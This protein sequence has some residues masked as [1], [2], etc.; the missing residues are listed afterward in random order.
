MPHQKQKNPLTPRIEN[1]T[2][3]YRMEASTESDAAEIFIYDQIGG[4]WGV[5]ASQFVQDL[6]GITAN[7][8]NLRVN[9]PGGDVYD[10]VAIMNALKRHKAKV[11]A[12]VDGLAASAASFI[13]Q[14]ADEI[15]MGKGAEIMIHDALTIAIGNPADFREAA[16][17][18]DRISNTIASVYADRAGGTRDEWRERMVAETWY[19]AEE[20]VAA[21]L[22]DSIVGTA[23]T[24]AEDLK[25][26][27]DFS[28]FAYAG[29]RAAPA[30]TPTNAT[31][32]RRDIQAHL[33]EALAVAGQWR[34]DLAETESP[35]QPHTKEGADMSDSLL[36]GVIKR[37]GIDPKA[38]DVSEEAVLAELDEALAERAEDS[39]DAAA[40]SSV[41]Q[42]A[43]GTVVLD[44]AQYSQLLNDA[45]AGRD[46]R[47]Q[48]IEE[49][50]NRVVDSA[51]ESGRIPPARREHWI[52]A[53]KAD[54][55]AEESLNALAP[56][57]VPV[58]AK[59]Y[60]GG[61][62]QAT[63]EDTVYS[64]VF[65]TAETTKES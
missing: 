9:S 18:L 47:N 57:L 39:Q 61:V 60:T 49:H 56:G 2:S 55:G 21:G 50:R 25:N 17:F 48:Q 40:S 65:A 34:N 62:D 54:P 6:S 15:V 44:E 27:L 28:V 4:W 45:S 41:Q 29:R 3:W 22:A 1:K 63:D 30:P 12:T 46:A 51:I 42:P 11:V 19:T 7:T 14:A 10:A 52:K 13:I 32:A 38:T 20:A 53:L 5:E 23:E 43:P 31:P 64:K 8:I 16:D 24:E 59:G 35:N 36:Q 37:L 33:D 26:R 58:E